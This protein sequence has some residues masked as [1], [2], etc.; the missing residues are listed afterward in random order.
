MHLTRVLRASLRLNK[1][2]LTIVDGPAG[3][4]TL[5][6]M[7]LR[8]ACQCEHCVLPQTN[9]K[10]FATGS[11]PLNTVPAP[12]GAK[13]VGD[14]LDIQWQD[15]H[16]SRF[17]LSWIA[18]HT[19]TSGLASAHSYVG[20]TPWTAEDVRREGS[21]SQFFLDYKDLGT[22]SGLLRAYDQLLE[23]GLLFVRG[24]PSEKTSD[25][26]CE[27]RRLVGKFGVLRETIYGQVWDV[28]NRPGTENIAY[29]NLN[30]GLHADMQ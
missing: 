3:S 2:A 29:T 19:S 20:Y 1:S 23:S 28:V 15:S 17:P 6:F 30:L 21:S 4:Q 10:L 14:A 26:D 27:L 8:D 9:S 11:L 24:V 16:R 5:S 22:P 12:G 7:W 25:E 18:Q 13:I